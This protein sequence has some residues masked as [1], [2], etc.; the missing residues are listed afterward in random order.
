M[1]TQNWKILSLVGAAL[2]PRPFFAAEALHP[3]THQAS[4]P[5][6]AESATIT[7]RKVKATRV[8]TTVS[9]TMD[10][11]YCKDQ[12]F[13]DPGGSM[14]CPYTRYD[15]PKPAYEVTYSFKDQPMA[16]D[17]YGNGDFTFRV[18]FRPEELPPALRQA[19]SAHKENRAELATYFQVTTSRPP[20]RTA[21]IDQ[22]NSTF[23]AGHYIDSNWTHNNPACQD[24]V[25][26]KTVTKPS[27]YMTVRVDPVPP[28]LPVRDSTR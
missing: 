8:F 23:C 21:A 16:S 19:L 7:F 20:T 2:M 9:S 18:Y 13:R 12:Q 15:S 26:F 5:V 17:E 1:T 4:I 3:F 6:T 24:R 14:Y 10:P 28:R 11:D 25:V 22:A 27:D